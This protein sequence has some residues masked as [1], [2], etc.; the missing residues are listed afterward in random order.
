MPDAAA[1]KVSLIRDAEIE[2]TIAV[3]AA[4]LFRAA[5]LEPSSVEIYLVKDK[6]LNAF[7]AGGQKLFINTGLLMRAE[8]PGQV[9]G[10]IAHEAG[11][12][13]GG[14]LSRTHEA[15][16]QSTAQTILAYVLGGA[17]ALGTGR[18][19]VGQAIILGGQQIGQRTFLQYSRTQESAADQAAVRFLET[20]GQSAKGLLEFMETLGD[21]ELLSA[22]HQDPYVRTHPMSRER[23]NFLQ[24]HVARSSHSA[25]PP[26]AELLQRHRRMRGKLRGF[27]EPVASTLRR[28]KETDGSV[29]ARYARAVAF[30]RRPDLEKALPLIDGLLAEYPGDPFFHEL[31][32]QMLFENGHAKAALEP[33]R[34][35]VQL[36]PHSPLLRAELAQVQLELD[37]PALLESAIANL[38]AALRHEA[39]SAFTWHQLAIAYGRDGQMGLSS[40]ALAEEAM[41]QGRKDDARYQAGRAGKLLPRGSPGW[42][43]AQDILEVTKKKK[44]KE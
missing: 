43:K 5:G 7:V 12:I 32:G 20:T 44:K 13:A 35:A 33:Y 6:S 8:H 36:M 16:R 21:Q 22:R 41:L 26:A 30:Y 17:A 14:H 3:Y 19:D 24:A 42:L 38:R 18:A 40:L 34:M 39:G 31:K 15:L 37:D 10:V 4:P 23:V 27:L 11:H 25:K 1:K 29:E 2:N 28:Y 9:I